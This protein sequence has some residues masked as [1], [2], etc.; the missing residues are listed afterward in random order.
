VFYDMTEGA[1]AEFIQG[2]RFHPDH[3]HMFG[4]SRQS[5]RLVE[6]DLEGAADDT[7]KVP[8]VKSHG[9]FETP[10][11]TLAF[12][13]LADVLISPGTSQGEQQ[14]VRMFPSGAVLNRIDSPTPHLGNAFQNLVAL[15]SEG[16]LTIGY[17]LPPNDSHPKNWAWFSQIQ[18]PTTEINNPIDISALTRPGFQPDITPVKKIKNLLAAGFQVRATAVSGDGNVIVLHG[19][20]KQG[21]DRLPVPMELHVF[22]LDDDKTFRFDGS[23]ES[24]GLALNQDGS[25]LA[26]VVPNGTVRYYRPT[27]LRPLAYQEESDP[28][29][30]GMENPTHLLLSPDG[31]RTAI[32]GAGKFLIKE[33]DPTVIAMEAGVPTPKIF[34]AAFSHDGQILALGHKNEIRLFETERGTLIKTLKPPEGSSEADY[35][36]ITFHLDNRFVTAMGRD[37]V[38]IRWDTDSTIGNSDFIE[39]DIV[40]NLGSNYPPHALSV[41]ER[42]IA[43]SQMGHIQFTSP[44]NLNPVASVPIPLHLYSSSLAFQPNGNLLIQ[45][46]LSQLP[47]EGHENEL[48]WIMRLPQLF[49]EPGDQ[50]GDDSGG[51]QPSF[52]PD[53]AP[54]LLMTM[55]ESANEVVTEGIENLKAHFSTKPAQTGRPSAN[56][57]TPALD[58]DELKKMSPVDID[59]IKEDLQNRKL[60]MVKIRVGLSRSSVAVYAIPEAGENEIS[61]HLIVYDLTHPENVISFQ[62]ISTPLNPIQDFKFNVE[63]TKIVVIFNKPVPLQ[64]LDLRLNEDNSDR[65]KNMN[66]M[67]ASLDGVVA[68]SAQNIIAANQGNVVILYSGDDEQSQGE[69]VNTQQYHEGS[70]KQITFNDDGTLM[71]IGDSDGGVSVWTVGSSPTILSFQRFHEGERIYSLEFDPSGGTLAVGS[72]KAILWDYRRTGV[73]EKS[74]DGQNPVNIKPLAVEHNIRSMEFLVGG[75]YISTINL[76]HGLQI[77]DAATGNEIW[78]INTTHTPEHISFNSAQRSLTVFYY[79]GSAQS[80]SPLPLAV[81]VPEARPVENADVTE[82]LEQGRRG[83]A[84]LDATITPKHGPLIA[85]GIDTETSGSTEGDVVI[86][87]ADTK[88]TVWRTTFGD[89][90]TSVVFSPNGRFLAAGFATTSPYHWDIDRIITEEEYGGNTFGDPIE[91]QIAVAFT[92]SNS[93]LLTAGEEGIVH[94]WDPETTEIKTDVTFQGGEGHEEVVDMTVNSQDVVFTQTESISIVATPLGD[95]GQKK[96]IGF[97]E[98]EGGFTSSH[99]ASPDGRLLAAVIQ[100]QLVVHDL[101][102]DRDCYVFDV[103]NAREVSFLPTVEERILA[104]SDD[105][106]IQ[107]FNLRFPSRPLLILKL[108]DE[109][110]FRSRFSQNGQSLV[111]IGGDNR[112]LEWNLPFGPME[113]VAPSVTVDFDRLANLKNVAEDIERKVMDFNEELTQGSISP[114]GT[115]VAAGTKKG[116]IVLVNPK[117]DRRVTL[118]GHNGGIGSLLFSPDGRWL[119]SK[120]EDYTLRLWNV[121]D[122]NPRDPLAELGESDKIEN[123]SIY[124]FDFSPDGTILIGNCSQTFLDN[125][126][127]TF[128][129]IYRWK[130]GSG[131]FEKMEPFKKPVEEIW[132]VKY[133][134]KGTNIATLSSDGIVYLL[135]AVSGEIIDQF[136]AVDEESDDMDFDISPKTG[137]LI[138]WNSKQ[139]HPH[140]W[141]I[142]QKAG[143]SRLIDSHFDHSVGLK[144]LVRFSPDGRIVVAQDKREGN[145]YFWSME[146]IGSIMTGDVVF[147]IDSDYMPDIPDHY[148]LDMIFNPSTRNI[149]LLFGMTH[150]TSLSLVNLINVLKRPDLGHT[151]N[152]W[153][154]LFE[155]FV[156]PSTWRWDEIQSFRKKV[157]L[158]GGPL[159][160]FT[161][162]FLTTWFEAGSGVAALIG[163]LWGLLHLPGSYK[164]NSDGTI[165]VARGMEVFWPSVKKAVGGAM[166]LGLISQFGDVVSPG[167]LASAAYLIHQ[168][169]NVKS[170]GSRREKSQRLRQ[171]VLPVV[172]V[173]VSS[174]GEYGWVRK[175]IRE[176]PS[177]PFAPALLRHGGTYLIYW[178]HRRRYG[179]ERSVQS[180]DRRFDSYLV[181][182]SAT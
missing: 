4:F 21:D 97:D 71:A 67:T 107:L 136:K 75:R 126:D 102:A 111:S 57:W 83:L 50:N 103:E 141:Q 157:V 12:D 34:S 3:R 138:V 100:R 14:I 153:A 146:L 42:L 151:T 94:G 104:V 56:A 127:N 96:V 23:A 148:L 29:E 130:I 61:P 89:E 99:A 38:L 78:G 129:F 44:A 112:I 135:D 45:R 128:N 139:E 95:P 167:V 59:F 142:G 169:L 85:V 35:F 180:L 76:G 63:E 158:L 47:A 30:S 55:I 11:A 58:V 13:A 22:K 10:Y 41:D 79:D 70:I 81:E 161:I 145:V 24:V 40:G 110:G 51:D 131:K 92:W 123:V 33:R 15:D 168:G 105:T 16:T 155:L 166:A 119:V 74:E 68:W 19:H 122:L 172:D 120:G 132:I 101:Q 36:S 49:D 27:S 65:V 176:N 54:G 182:K 162:V 46:D 144:G 72:G 114:D 43:S 159:E 173:G 77:W 147:R 150:P 52:G 31:N 140:M 178:F 181:I 133:G 108:K 98:H 88:E 2:I 18:L 118:K 125:F 73:R 91:D 17:R 113:P 80:W 179:S 152:T 9:P 93:L 82:I 62:S 117:N 175:R 1:N 87:R 160:L 149:S 164:I 5:K 84:L 86:F 143:E 109:W 60:K 156:N 6:W 8:Q 28:W 53:E 26:A 39:A 165:V 7:S 66:Q 37:G 25:V 163:I 48:F 171:A 124:Y 115:W 137:D 90:P 121:G 69:N 116:P 64:M 106:H 170:L 154:W 177:T 32:V 174:Y 20:A 134:P